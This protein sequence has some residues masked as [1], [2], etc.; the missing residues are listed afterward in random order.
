[1]KCC[2]TFAGR[3]S[4]LKG[5]SIDR[6]GTFN[7][8]QVQVGGHLFGITTVVRMVDIFPRLFSVENSLFNIFNFE[9]GFYSLENGIL[10]N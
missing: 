2:I 8:F 10:L 5:Q 1:M 9:R 4:S 3:S 7:S 6:D